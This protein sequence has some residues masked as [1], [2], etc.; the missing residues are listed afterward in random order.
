MSLVSTQMCGEHH[1]EHSKPETWLPSMWDCIL[2]LP[3]AAARRVLCGPWRA[4]SNETTV[5]SEKRE[6][7]R[8]GEEGRERA[9]ADNAT[10]SQLSNLPTWSVALTTANCSMAHAEDNAQRSRWGPSATA[11]AGTPQRTR[12]VSRLAE[13]AG[14]YLRASQKDHHGIQ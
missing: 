3:R 8:I 13:S 2:L 7:R 4:A 1:V 6:E 10:S 9:L 14:L 5:A 12:R 11:N